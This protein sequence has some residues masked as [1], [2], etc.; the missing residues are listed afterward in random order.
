VGTEDYASTTEM[1]DW[2]LEKL[3]IRRVAGVPDGDPLGLLTHAERG[4]FRIR[5]FGGNDKPAHCDHLRH[6]SEAVA[7][8]EARWGTPAAEAR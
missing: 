8:L 1:S 7:L 6:L 3:R 4:G 5:G 2:L